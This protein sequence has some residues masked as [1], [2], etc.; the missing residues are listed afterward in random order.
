MKNKKKLIIIILILLIIVLSIK[1]KIQS[2]QYNN[3]VLK[4]FLDR[5][6]IKSMKNCFTLRDAKSFDCYKKNQSKIFDNLKKR[7]NVNYIS[8]DHARWSDG[9]KNFDAQTYHRDIKPNLFKHH[10]TYPD[11]YTLICFLDKAKHIQGSTEYIL[12][13]GDCLLFNAFN[14]H[15]GSNMKFNNNKKRRVIQFFHI[16]FNEKEQQ[17]FNKKH[18][19]AEHYNSDFI[20]KNINHYIDTRATIELFNLVPL[21][22]PMKLYNPK[23]NTYITLVNNSKIIT[24]IDG[25][26]YYE[27]F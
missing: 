2:L 14:L 5:Q 13:P 6:T 25:V 20:L 4:N 27:K 7:F 21:V 10:G 24:N 26:T 18:S 15:K 9:T 16:F 12:E 1:I 22:L 8:V 3:Y 23:Q 19:Y 11:V 17:E